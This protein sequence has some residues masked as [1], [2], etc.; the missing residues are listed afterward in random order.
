MADFLEKFVQNH[1]EQFDD[2]FHSKKVWN[3]IS[4]EMSPPSE[5][6]KHIWWK[7]AAVFF[8]MSTLALM[9]D[10]LQA[11]TSS[12]EASAHYEE[13]KLAE[14]YYVNLI[15]E[16]RQ[17]LEQLNGEDLTREF[18]QDLDQLDQ[19]YEDLGDRFEGAGDDRKIIDAMI[20]NLQLRLE[21]L[22]R[23]IEILDRLR[24]NEDEEFIN[25]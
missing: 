5:S 18:L 8:L 2:D 25:A 21:I 22:N 23:Q 13:F 24:D 1:R 10:K 6:K 11:P 7:V 12:L 17:Q 15:A 16:R 19:L 20:N 9:W 14:D 3:R 4:T